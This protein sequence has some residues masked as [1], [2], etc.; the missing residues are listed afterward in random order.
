ME[1]RLVGAVV[2]ISILTAGCTGFVFGDGDLVFDS[3]ETLIQ[4]E[5][6]G[7]EGY[8]LQ[9]AETQTFNETLSIG[10]DGADRRV[11]VTSHMANY[12]PESEL[13]SGI[14]TVQLAVLTTPAAS[15]A[16]QSVNPL[17]RMDSYERAF[18]YLPETDRQGFEKYGN[19]TVEPFGESVNVTVLAT[20]TDDEEEIPEAFIHIMQL[21]RPSGDAVLAYAMHPAEESAEA[22]SI[23]A[24]FSALEYTPPAE[25]EDE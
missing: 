15:V 12:G 6:L 7:Q 11:I 8:E 22:P 19:Y 1:A 10:E 2:A 16:G 21:E 14:G 24:L 5:T 20:E 23:A 13:P 18:R 3:G 9:H 4:N 25:A 17:L